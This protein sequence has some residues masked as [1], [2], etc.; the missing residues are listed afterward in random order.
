MEGIVNFEEI[1]EQ[2][3]RKGYFV[4][5]DFPSLRLDHAQVKLLKETLKKKNI[6]FKH[7][8]AVGKKNAIPSYTKE[9]A[10]HIITALRKGVPPQVG[11]SLFSVGRQNLIERIHKDL[12]G[13]THGASRVCFMNADY[14]LG[15]THSLYRLRE[16]AFYLGFVVSVVTLSESFCPIHDFMTVY[17]KVMWNL[18]TPD[19]RSKPALEN[20]LGRWLQM[21]RELGEEQAIHII[22]GL[23]DNLKSALHAYHESQSPIRPNEEKR[24]L[25]LQYLSGKRLYLRD[26]KKFDINERIE[27]DNALPMLGYMA[28]LFKNLG[29]KGICILFDE[30]DP[31][32]SFARY[33]QQDQAY[34]NLFNIILNSQQSTHCYFLYATTPSFFDNYSRYW[35][36]AYRISENN[37]FE[38]DKLTV[39]ELQE[40]ASNIYGIYCIYKGKTRL[41]N[42]DQLLLKLPQEPGFS[43]SVGNFVRK[44]IGILDELQ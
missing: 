44:C 8:T 9:D 34:N 10:T 14:G 22:R 5:A 23:P 41:A 15:K 37:I 7:K 20:V 2:A 26:L 42:V 21:I 3:E 35:P 39:Q 13:V 24:M 28:S 30:A 36:S 11:I 29:Y 38:L 12:N 18:R 43:D 40:L 25:V 17:D 4:F 6:P 33:E 19:Q 27:S 16:I 32:H 1:I 31:I